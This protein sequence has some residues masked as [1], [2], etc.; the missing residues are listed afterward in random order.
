MYNITTDFFLKRLE[1]SA[2]GLIKSNPKLLP[3]AYLRQTKL[4]R[5][6][7]LIMFLV[8]NV[9]LFAQLH[10]ACCTNK[11]KSYNLQSDV[12]EIVNFEQ[13]IKG[14]DAQNEIIQSD[15]E[16]LKKLRK[17]ASAL[18]KSTQ[19]PSAAASFMLRR[20]T[21]SAALIH[22]ENI[23]RLFNDDLRT[24]RY[25]ENHDML[26]CT[27]SNMACRVFSFVSDQFV[28]AYLMEQGIE[29]GK[30]ES[31]MLMYTRKGHNSQIPWN[32]LN[33]LV[34]DDFRLATNKISGSNCS[35]REELQ[36]ELYHFTS[37][38]S[39]TY[40]DA[41]TS[42]AIGA[43]KE[44]TMSSNPESASNVITALNIIFR[45]F[46]LSGLSNH[47]NL[48][49]ELARALR[50]GSDIQSSVLILN[51][52]FDKLGALG[53]HSYQTIVSAAINFLPKISSGILE[54]S[55]YT[56]RSLHAKP[57]E[58]FQENVADRIAV[59]YPQNKTHT[60]DSIPQCQNESNDYS[61]HGIARYMSLSSVI[62]NSEA[63]TASTST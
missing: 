45:K 5:K 15:I 49:L 1:N 29:N 8:T 42:R 4:L 31:T 34:D 18:R 43:R 54:T 40:E 12:E 17:E 32:S 25:L 2:Q 19:T 33:N 41:D 56:L 37:S 36:K 60:E 23:L 20:K 9:T 3:A 55:E 48:L 30:L 14:L 38:G 61:K 10:G 57:K 52:L 6:T 21:L 47:L 59:L 24:K 11:I 35:N 44:T 50:Q 58:S 7:G 62:L 53:L 13:V 26:G 28:K 39:Y 22:P 46:E 16:A 27:Y 63:T 51:F